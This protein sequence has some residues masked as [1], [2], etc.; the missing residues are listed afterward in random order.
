VKNRKGRGYK[1]DNPK[2]SSREDIKADVLKSLDNVEMVV[3]NI[4]L[5]ASGPAENSGF[6]NN[7]DGRAIIHKDSV[8]SWKKEK[9]SK[10]SRKMHKKSFMLETGK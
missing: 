4:V 3:K 2:V 1:M 6:E 8:R 7:L 10:N 9:R 5:L